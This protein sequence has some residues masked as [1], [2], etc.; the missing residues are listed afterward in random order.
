MCIDYGLDQADKWYE[1]KPEVVVENEKIKLLLDMWIQTDK[2]LKSEYVSTIF[3]V[4]GMLIL[5]QD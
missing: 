5:I 4:S 2:I 3:L 1:H